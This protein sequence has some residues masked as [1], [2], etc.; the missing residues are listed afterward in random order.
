MH[1]VIAIA[2]PILLATAWACSAGDEDVKIAIHVQAHNA[3]QTCES[4][5]VI[6]SCGDIQTTYS[7][8]E[9]VDVFGVYFDFDGLTCAEYGLAWPEEWGTGV[10]T[11]CGDLTMGNITHP[12]DW[13]SL[14][15]TECQPGPTMISA[16]TW[17]SAD[18]PGV[19]A[20]VPRP[21]TGGLPPFLGIADCEFVQIQVMCALGAGV[22]GICGDDPCGPSATEAGTWG[23]IKVMFR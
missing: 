18:G 14:A 15:W 12:G 4:R 5:P 22:C 23:A 21:A 9:D 17:L 3:E 19:V 13:I 20:P 8:C 11:S 1:R 7:D 2:V 16:W 6:M 10:T